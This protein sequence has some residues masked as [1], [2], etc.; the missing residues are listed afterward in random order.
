MTAAREADPFEVAGDLPD[1]SGRDQIGSYDSWKLATP[2]EYSDRPRLR[3]V[4]ADRM[5]EGSCGRRWGT[6]CDLL[7]DHWTRAEPCNDNGFA[8]GGKR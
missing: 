5:P 8:P 1:S 3:P 2:P 6:L 7:A 4:W